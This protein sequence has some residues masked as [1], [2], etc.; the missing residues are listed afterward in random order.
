MKKVYRSEWEKLMNEAIQKKN[1]QEISFLW[2]KLD[3][4]ENN[5]YFTLPF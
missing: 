3:E 4:V 1:I 2:S 5:G